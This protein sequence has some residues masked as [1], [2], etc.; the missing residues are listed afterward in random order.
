MLQMM[1]DIASGV[2]YL[3]E[4]GIAHGNIQGVNI[5][6]DDDL[7]CLI[8][9]FYH[10]SL[11]ISAEASER[12]KHGLVERMAMW[13]SP[14]VIRSAVRYTSQGDVYSFAI[15][16]AEILT[17]GAPFSPDP[18]D[19]SESPLL[20]LLDRMLSVVRRED[21]RPVLPRTALLDGGLKDVIDACWAEA[22]EARP[23]SGEARNMLRDVW[24]KLGYD[25]AEWGERVLDF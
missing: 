16:R 4:K 19:P 11:A 22:P 15:V 13:Y 3:H 1:I 25:D 9:G 10:S 7:N 23:T 2:E 5:L 21:Q 20:R 6:V 8:G 12:E 17:E 24:D 18:L 14:E